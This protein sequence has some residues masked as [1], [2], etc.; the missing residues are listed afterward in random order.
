MKEQHVK[1][2]NKILEK[3]RE[4]LLY[5]SSNYAYNWVKTG[6]RGLMWDLSRKYWRIDSIVGECS[7]KFKTEYKN[8]DYLEK[9]YEEVIDLMGYSILTC[10][11]L[12]I[13]MQD[14]ENTLPGFTEKGV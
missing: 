10:L 14:K 6:L 3:V 2:I 13:L 11:Y 12:Q 7:N 9:L 4:I 8:K 5:K 1:I